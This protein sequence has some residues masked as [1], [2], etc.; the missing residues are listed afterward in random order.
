MKKSPTIYIDDHPEQLDIDQALASV[1]EQRRK[2]ALSYRQEHDQQ[3]SLAVYQ[4]LQRA[5]SQEYGIDEKPSFTFNEHGKPLLEQH[6]EIFFNMSHCRE[7]AACVVHSVPVGIDVESLTS[8]DAALIDQVMNDDEQQ[9]IAHSTHPQLAFI[10]LWT[11]KESLLK[12]LGK[13][14]STNLRNVLI[15]HHDQLLQHCHFHTT[16]YPHFVCTTCWC[17]TSPPLLLKA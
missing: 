11:M 13:G 5:L 9:L 16:V 6:P 15:D 7:A 2:H 17:L 10:R 8:Y 3:L 14:L 1:S 12:M 4:L